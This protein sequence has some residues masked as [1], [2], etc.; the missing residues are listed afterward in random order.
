MKKFVIAMVATVVM[1]GCVLSAE[2]NGTLKKVMNKDGKWSVVVEKK[3][4]KGTDPTSVTLP[5]AADA[6]VFKGDVKKDPD[7]AKK[8][9][10]SAG[11][12]IK[13]GFKDDMF[14]DVGDKGIPVRVFT[15][16]EGDKEQV[17]KIYVLPPGKKA[18]GQ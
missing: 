15:D 3:G 1:V 13:G 5:V 11:D 7:N 6:K 18:G 9:I 8:S 4:K 14:K 10:Y 17:T 2:Y 12:E 16:G